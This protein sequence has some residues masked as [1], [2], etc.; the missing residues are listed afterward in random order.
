MTVKGSKNKLIDLLKPKLNR[1]NSSDSSDSE[2][3][4]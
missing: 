3:D 4:S 2:F 1:S